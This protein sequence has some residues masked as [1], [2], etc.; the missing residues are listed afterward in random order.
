MRILKGLPALVLAAS[1]LAAGQAQAQTG[2][3]GQIAFNNHCRTCHTTDEGDNR[4]GPNLHNIIGR[5][6]AAAEGYGY[7]SAFES[8]DFE[9]TPEKMNAFIE[10][11]DA[12]V[13]GNNM[14]PYSGIEDADVRQAIVDH[15]VAESKAAGGK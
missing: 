11:P 5:K 9:W 4:L 2:Q 8:A 7:S 12:V 15:L 6:T 10:N 3:D 1:T 13:R 14:K